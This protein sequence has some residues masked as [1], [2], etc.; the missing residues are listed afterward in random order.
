[1]SSGATAGIGFVSLSL[2]LSLVSGWQWADQ[3]PLIE[4]KEARLPTA[5]T[6]LHVRIPLTNTARPSSRNILY[7]KM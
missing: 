4:I 3:L 2:S 1:M 5:T 7:C 6:G